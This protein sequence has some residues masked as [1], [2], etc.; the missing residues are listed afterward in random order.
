[1]ESASVTA[2]VL[3]KADVEQARRWFLELESHPERYLFETHA[4]FAFTQGSFGEIG[5]RFQ[6]RERFHG[7]KL[8]L[9]FELIEIT[10]TCF[11]FRLVRPPLP[12]WGV[13]VIERAN[14]AI[15]HLRLEIGGTTRLG[16]CFLR[17]PLVHGAIQR[18]I[19]DEVQ[20]I[21]ASIEAL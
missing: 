8:T 3:V 9:G 15:T 6:T 13:F 5:A 10:D 18:Q 20:H 16:A 11:R 1:M 19:R 12:V 7:L 21:K 17:L 14:G 4:G 2:Q